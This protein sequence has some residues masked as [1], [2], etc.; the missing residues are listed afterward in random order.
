VQTAQEIPAI[1]VTIP[2]GTL[3]ANGTIEWEM[4]RYAPNNANVKS[5][6]VYLGGDLVGGQDVTTTTQTGATGTV[7]NRGAVDKQVAMQG[8]YGDSGQGTIRRTTVATQDAQVVA[9]QVSI[10]N[11]ADYAVVEA[12]M[13]GVRPKR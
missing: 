4:T 9:V 1:T 5:F 2:A 11:A 3:G 10:A 7:K 8:A 6:K 12:F 13:V